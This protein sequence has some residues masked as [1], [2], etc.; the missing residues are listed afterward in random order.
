MA[1]RSW[2]FAPGHSQRILQ[3]AFDSGA[4]QV[5]LDLED[6][7]PADLKLSARSA[8]VEV[9][10]SRQAWVRVNRACTDLGEADL[11][12]VAGLAVGLRL[13]KVESAAEVA[14]AVERAPGVPITATIESAL[15]IV[16]AFEIASAPGVVSLSYG[17]ADL[18]L[19]LGIDPAGEEETLHTRSSLVVASRAAGLE[20]PSDGVWVAFR[21]EAG[22]RREAERARR[23]GYFGKSAIHPSQLAVIHE[24]FAPT[25]AELAW[26]EKV[27]EAF[28][29]AGGAA[30]KTG[31][32]EMV[33]APVAARARRILAS[34]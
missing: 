15:G 4:D 27:L 8:V 5:L 2:L 22:L 25:A 9:L 28:E 16:R 18:G 21:D 31:T 1:A 7:V 17:G 32:G 34:R 20:A 26:A 29:A 13:P 10:N 3:K 23:L 11:E 30:T 33:D 12:S 24:V 14:W 19:D 6:A